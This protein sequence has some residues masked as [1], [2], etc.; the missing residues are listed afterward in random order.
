MVLAPLNNDAA[1]NL[2]TARCITDPL[3]R[4]KRLQS[5]QNNLLIEGFKS[6]AVRCI[7]VEK[8]N[9]GPTVKSVNLC[10]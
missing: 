9:E 5:E 2:V 4:Q 3:K 8:Y 10:P 6:G 1:K 7:F